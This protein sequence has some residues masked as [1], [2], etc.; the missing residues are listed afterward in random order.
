MKIP[1][2]D[3]LSRLGKDWAPSASDPLAEARA[4]HI[5]AGNPILDLIG[6]TATE[7]GLVYP[8]DAFQGALDA[9]AHTLR[10]AFP[11]NPDPLG[12]PAARG[13]VAR[14]YQRRGLDTSPESLFLTPGTSLAYLTAFRLLLNPGD[15][16]LVPSPGYPLF[17]DLCAIAGIEAR[18]Y[19]LRRADARWGVD[20]DEVE[21][22]CTPRTRAIALVSPHNPTGHV[23]TVGELRAIQDLCRRRGLALLFDEVFSETL[24]DGA[25]LPRPEGEGAPLVLLLNGFSKMFSL[26]GWKV[27]WGLASGE[28]ARAFLGAAAHFLDAFLPM[29]DFTQAT[30]APLLDAGDPPVLQGLNGR[31]CEMR[32]ASA[33]ALGVSDPGAGVYLTVPNG[34]AEDDLVLCTRLLR[35]TGILTHPGYYYDLPGHLVLTCLSPSGTGIGPFE[36][37]RRWLSGSPAQGVPPQSPNFAP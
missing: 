16:I 26:P 35:E 7:A 15:N 8:A 13:A 30:V 22:Q 33:G 2:R 24:S 17:D 5:A 37:I 29:P 28:H 25:P 11:Y 6:T 21:F 3:V 36:R 31:L 34:T 14:F 20:P 1:E 23:A 18:H 32:R 10:P 9:A 12:A 19:H 4:E 27:A